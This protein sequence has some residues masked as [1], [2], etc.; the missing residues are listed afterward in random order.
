MDNEPTPK[1]GTPAAEPNGAPPQAA[2]SPYVERL[3]L[4]LT[5]AYIDI[6]S[7]DGNICDLETEH[8]KKGLAA[9][10][11][12][13]LVEQRG[14]DYVMALYRDGELQ[15]LSES[16]ADLPYEPRKMLVDALTSLV[17]AD[18]SADMREIERASAIAGWLGIKIGR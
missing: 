3:A 1:P 2:A 11:L 12:P 8:W 16:F 9:N 18:G 13:N 7:A 5:L 10:N 14:L 15:P 17:L 6:A 4:W